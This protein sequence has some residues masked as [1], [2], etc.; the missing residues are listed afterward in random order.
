MPQWARDVVN[1]LVGEKRQRLVFFG[2]RLI[3]IR[4]QMGINV[5]HICLLLEQLTPGPECLL[6]L[7]A[8]PLTHLHVGIFRSTLSEVSLI[9]PLKAKAFA[10]YAPPPSLRRGIARNLSPRVG[11]RRSL[12]LLSVF[13]SVLPGRLEEHEGSR[14]PVSLVYLS[15]LQPGKAVM[16]YCCK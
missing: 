10:Q 6:L 11:R 2:V 9:K 15:V 12:E 16:F 7:L 8:Q 4:Q 3:L 14:L 5:R 13:F 1:H